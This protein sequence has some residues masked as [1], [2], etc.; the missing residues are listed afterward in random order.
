MKKF[1]IFLVAL[2]GFLVS[3]LNAQAC[4][5]PK[6]ECKPAECCPTIPSCCKVTK[7]LD[8]ATIGDVNVVPV[9][10]KES[11]TQTP[12]EPKKPAKKQDKLAIAVIKE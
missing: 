8:E 6:T 2:S 1:F 11:I 10:N 3:E 7:C 9:L 5:T 12:T 4:C